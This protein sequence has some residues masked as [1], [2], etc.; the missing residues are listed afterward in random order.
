[1]S[2]ALPFSAR[3]IAG[4]VLA[5]AAGAGLSWGLAA[6][7]TASSTG[8]AAPSTALPLTPAEHALLTQ[9]GSLDTW[10]DEEILFREGLRRGFAWDDL[11][12]RRQLQ[13]RA[14]LALL[15]DAAP[16]ATDDASLDA[17][18][19]A[20]TDR[21]Q[22]PARRAFE[23]VYLSR[24]RHGAALDT[25]AARVGEQLAARPEAYAELG[26]A[27]AGGATRRAQ[28]PAEVIADFGGAFEQALATFP[29]GSWQGPV[30]TPLGAHW[31]RVTAVEPARPLQLDE[32]RAA[33]RADVV[34]EHERLT[35]QAELARLRSTY[36]VVIDSRAVSAQFKPQDAHGDHHD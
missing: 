12:V 30:M 15:E 7:S 29:I 36:R 34:A 14:R 35:L 28:T 10:M 24:S 4:W 32:A 11:I 20:H 6:R 13:R 5:F 8:D 33:L 18:R 16:A 25:D 1:M 23:H 27:F 19:Q 22:A 21:Y 31:V 2:R 9:A 3:A 17:Y 26:D